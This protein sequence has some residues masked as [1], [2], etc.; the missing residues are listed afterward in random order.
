M[1]IGGIWLLFT[2]GAIGG[3][4]IEVRVPPQFVVVDEISGNDRWHKCVAEADRVNKRNER[5]AKWGSRIG[6][7]LAT[8]GFFLQGVAQWL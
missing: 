6:L 2:Y 5:R 8:L 7:A 3:K 4:W 1:D